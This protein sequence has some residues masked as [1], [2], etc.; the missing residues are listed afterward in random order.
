M[1]DTTVLRLSGIGVPDYSVRGTVKQTLEPISMLVSD[2]LIWRDVNGTIV[3]TTPVQF[4]KY[5]S[6]ISAEDVDPPAF[7]GLWPGQEIIVDCI[8]E[9]SFPLGSAATRPIMPN[10]S[11]LVG[12]HQFYRPQLTMVVREWNMQ[13]SEY[14]DSVSWS[15]VL[16]EV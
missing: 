12:N 7:D 2:D 8:S 15:L 1:A 3:D 16:E 10:S 14:S 5:R 13:Q 9:L 6:E 11:R 4:R